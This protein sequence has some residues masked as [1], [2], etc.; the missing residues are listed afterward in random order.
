MFPRSHI[1]ELS[2]LDFYLLTACSEVR[3][4]TFTL[5]SDQQSNHCKNMSRYE[6]TQ[7]FGVG[8]L[9][10]QPLRHSKQKKKTKSGILFL[11]DSCGSNLRIEM[12]VS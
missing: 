2:A 9:P 12:F 6:S 1:H 3:V 10:K 7:L 11:E 5:A 8:N 4:D